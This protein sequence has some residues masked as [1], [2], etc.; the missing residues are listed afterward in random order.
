MARIV[1]RLVFSFR[2]KVWLC[3]TESGEFVGITAEAAEPVFHT[4]VKMP[5]Y[6]FPGQQKPKPLP[7][8]ST[9]VEV[10]LN[11]ERIRLECAAIIQ[12]SIAPQQANQ[13]ITSSL[14]A[15]TV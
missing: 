2:A 7:D 13:L 9:N 10:G 8:F 11:F 3:P 15:S 12:G 6:N 4:R 5:T 1:K 14:R